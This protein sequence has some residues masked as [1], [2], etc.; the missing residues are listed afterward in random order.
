MWANP[1]P[2]LSRGGEG[3]AGRK[4]ENYYALKPKNEEDKKW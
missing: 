1:A 2:A 3:G 4:N